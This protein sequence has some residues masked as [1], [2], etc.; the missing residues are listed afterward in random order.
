MRGMDSDSRS[1][2]ERRAGAICC[3]QSQ[4]QELHSLCGPRLLLT[5]WATELTVCIFETL[6]DPT[7]TVSTGC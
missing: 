6:L 1:C 5:R 3:S 4:H 2:E 7:F